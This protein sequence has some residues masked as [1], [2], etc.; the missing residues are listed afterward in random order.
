MLESVKISRRQSEIRQALA[1][2]VGKEKPEEAETRA[3]DDLDREYRS[4]ETRYRAALISEDTERR[5][6]GGELETRSSREWSSLVDQFEMR[7]VA[8][9]LD[10]KVALTG[11]TNEIV[12][13]LRSRG[14]YRGL[15]V[16]WEALEKR[17]GETVAS[18]VPAPTITR[19]IIDRIFADSV[20]GRMGTQYI[21]IDQGLSEWPVTTSA[22][23]AAWAAGETASVGGPTVFATTLATLQ[24][25]HNLGIQMK[26]TRKSLKQAGAALEDAVRRDM[27]GAMSMSLD[28]AIFQGTGASGQPAGIFPNSSYGITVDST[29]A[30]ASWAKFKAAI[31]SFIVANCA[32]SW[33]DVKML[34]RPEIASYMD[35]AAFLSNTAG[36]TE[37]DI[38]QRRVGAGNLILSSNA[39]A[40][41]SGSPATSQVLLTTT[42]NGVAPIFVG[43]WGAIDLIRDPYSDAASGGLRL[44]A[45]AT[46]DVTVARASQL[47]IL[48]A[49]KNS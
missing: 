5:E 11:A 44:T 46:V 18:G 37:F 29:A 21:A 17:T 30:S 25:A 10:E 19:P 36:L 9:H 42:V 38:L 49:V 13:E 34:M 7:Q 45:L 8:L 4:N 47:Q 15:P 14:G 32:S 6:A 22:V 12:T 40:A 41:P 33:S 28:A 48:S 23:T 2:L 20:A 35:G 3:M 16:P 43:A 31:T 1:G 26:I 27:N 39:V 24:P